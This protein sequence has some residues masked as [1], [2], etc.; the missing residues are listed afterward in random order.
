MQGR[1]RSGFWFCSGLLFI[2][3]RGRKGLN[4]ARYGSEPAERVRQPLRGYDNQRHQRSEADTPTGRQRKGI[5]KWK[6]YS[7]TSFRNASLK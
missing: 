4:D 2:K 6:P 1:E 7:V 5:R 3:R